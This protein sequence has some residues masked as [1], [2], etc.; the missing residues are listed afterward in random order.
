MQRICRYQLLVKEIIKYT[1]TQTPEYDLWTAVLSEM[2]EIVSEIDNSK[3]QRDMEEK[4]NRFI[5]RLEDDWRITKEN[6]SQLGH[7]LVA[8]AIEVTYS[9]LGSSVSKPKYLGCLLFSTYMIMVRPKK[10]TSYEPKHWFPLK[11]AEFEDLEDI[12][13]LYKENTCF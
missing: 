2:Q 1:S 12:E 11:I 6:V 5:E 10:L 13:G 4:T 8:G 3:F 9:A 7:L